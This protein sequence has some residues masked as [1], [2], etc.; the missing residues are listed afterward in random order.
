MKQIKKEDLLKLYV[1]EQKTIKEVASELGVAVGSVYNYLRKYDIA[2]RNYSESKKV[3]K[4]KGWTYPQEAREKISTLHKGKTVSKT[5]RK[6]MSDSAKLKG[7]GRKKYR[8]DG[9]VAIYF[10]DHPQSNKDG[11]IMEHVLIMECL[12][13]RWLRDDE[14]VHHKN[15]IRNDNRKENLQLMNY[16]EHAKLHME[17][18]WRERKQGGMTY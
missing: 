11:F 10:P 7:I 4:E 5:T 8:K 3:L 15:K 16:K 17:E 18:L 6:K 14:V 12:I 9:Y 13:G 1:E 2:T